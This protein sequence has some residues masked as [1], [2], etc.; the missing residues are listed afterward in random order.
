MRGRVLP[1]VA[2]LVAV[3]LAGWAGPPPGYVLQWSDEFNGEALDAAKWHI[4]TG[5]RGNAVNT[6][7][8]ISERGG[9]LVITTYTDGHT[10][11]TGFIDTQNAFERTYGYFEARIAFQTGGGAHSAFWLQSPTVAAVGNPEVNGVEIDIFEHRH[12]DT[13]GRIISDGGSSALHWDGYGD[14]HKKKVMEYKNL[15]VASG[16]HTYGLLWTSNRYRVFIDDKLRWSVDGP[17]SR[18]PEFI[19]LTSEVD[20]IDSP[21]QSPWSGPSPAAGYGHLSGSTNQMLV[22]YVRVYAPAPPPW[23]ARQIP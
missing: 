9:H 17:I 10:N 12:L 22:D 16:F 1:C 3:A 13:R 14:Q 8:A 15:G 4:R 2:G 11:F 18:R 21:G 7:D 6:A 19:R 23:P 5:P 20:R